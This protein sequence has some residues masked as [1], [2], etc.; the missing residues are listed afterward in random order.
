M[1]AFNSGYH[2]QLGSASFEAGLRGTFWVDKESLDLLRI[3]DHATGIPRGANV[4]GV[5]SSIVFAPG[6]IGGKVV[7]LPQSAETVVKARNG[8]EKKNAMQFSG[9]QAYTSESVIQ[10]DAP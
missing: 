7:L 5:D 2:I 10:Y 4:T 8:E 1:T 9:C 6:R 3:E